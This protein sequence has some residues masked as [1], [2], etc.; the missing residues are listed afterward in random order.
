MI[1]KWQLGKL[2][3]PHSPDSYLPQ[4][5]A[6]HDIS[7]LSLEEASVARL[8]SLPPLH[9]DP[10]DRMI[11]CQAIHHDLHVLTVDWLVLQYPIQTVQTA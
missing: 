2:Q 7:S 6:A 5:R 11:V 1:V 4:A 8:V 3:L 9:R 10:F